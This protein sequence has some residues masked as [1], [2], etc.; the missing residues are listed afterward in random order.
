VAASREEHWPALARVV[1]L[2]ESLASLSAEEALSSS[3]Q[4]PLARQ[5]AVRFAQADVDAWRDRLDAAG[6]PCAPAPRPID[7]LTSPQVEANDLA[8]HHEH[9]QWGPV[10]QTGLLVKFSAT[11]GH[12]QRSAPLIGQHTREVLG[13]LG[14]AQERIEALLSRGTAVQAPPPE[15]LAPPN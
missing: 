15:P 13:E 3:P 10:T 11:P 8:A 1:D 6:V 5:L 2:P 12:L 4:G 9:P 14:Y 7:A